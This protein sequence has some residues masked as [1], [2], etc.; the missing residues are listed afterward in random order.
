[1]GGSQ[2]MRSWADL[3]QNSSQLL[4]SAAPAAPFPPLQARNLCR[5]L[6]QL[7][8]LSRQ[9][10]ARTNRYDATGQSIAATRLLAR[11]GINADQLAR[12]LKA[13]ELKTSF[14][15]V[16][17][18]EATTVEEYL[19]QVHEMSMLTAIL[20]SQRDNVRSFDDYMMKSLEDDWQK[21]KREFLN[22]LS[23]L[24]LSSGTPGKQAS[25]VSGVL[26]SS[27]VKA[28]PD[29]RAPNPFLSTPSQVVNAKAAGYAEAV[30]KLNAARERSEPFKV[31]STLKDTFL[32]FA[33]EKMGTKSVNMAKIWYLL[34][35]LLGEDF[36]YPSH[37]SRKMKMVFGARRHLEAGHEKYMLDTIQS[38]AAQ[39]ALG[40]STGNLQRVRAF[41]RVRLRDYGLL[42]FDATDTHRQPPIDT[43]WYQIYFC[44]RSGYYEEAKLVAQS[45]RA[46]R[47]YAPLLTEWIATGGAVSSATAT[48]AFEECEKMA[49]I[50]DRP[51]R[52][53]YDK[54]KMLLYA[55]LSGSRQQAE[56]LL[57]DIPVLF[58]TIEDFMWF[59]LSIT[60]DCC[61]GP[62]DGLVPYT[63]EDLQNYLT[64]F[65]PSYYTK[66]GKDPLVYPYVLLLSL[67]LQAAILYLTRE[68]S[69]DGDHIDGVHIA[70]ALADHGVLSEGASNKAKPGT[71]SPVGEITSI[72]RHYGLSYVRQNNLATAL[73]YYV[74]A[75]AAIGGGA[76][77]WSGQNS[78]DQQRQRNMMLKQLL[79]ELLLR[80]GGIALLLG[81]NGIGSEGALRRFLP[82]PT[83]QQQMLLE[84]ARHAQE[85]G[86]YEKAIEL[87]KRVG[88]FAMALEIVTRRL[89]EAICALATGR[90]DG[91]AKVAGLILAGNDIAETYKK[92]AGSGT[93]S[94]REAEQ[95]T[96]QQV[97][98][99]QL[100]GIV[101]FHK[102]FRLGRYPDA[103]AELP[104][105]SFLPLT[106]WTPEK[107]AEDLRSISP[108]VQ[109]CVPDLLKAALICLDNVP[110]RDGHMRTLK[111]KIANFVANTVP[112]NW[113]HDLYEQVARML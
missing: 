72:I 9:L 106:P 73:E 70:I 14:E 74:Q 41:L 12:E 43:T 55:V 1:M 57:R 27:A 28:L 89:S 100:E 20:N 66:N 104:R 82:D 63:L 83:M 107:S 37:L 19:Q 64:K 54:K 69:N 8:S 92:Q 98:F 99:R 45:S 5:S 62:Q 61:P 13:F 86:L 30:A 97:S 11:E 111:A 39:A 31:A 101:A 88:A 33:D 108:P 36:E 32:A 85:S 60:R 110:D 105:L 87:L 46:S 42:D 50:G 38:H 91:E 65:E 112:R 47:S 29:M 7:E 53:G 109:A 71:M 56:R 68:I 93:G 35:S 76:I 15:D 49:R 81:S 23:R 78:N 48:A 67:Q 75:A 94:S 52:A 113:P 10:K 3:L 17:P 24:P 16:F 21:E 90:A 84:A 77:S 6:D 18:V 95:V 80:D 4:Q 25:R 26:D 2:D 96:E 58:T 51:G 40:G 103:I 22:S 79:I 34:Q 44:L 102:L 59:M